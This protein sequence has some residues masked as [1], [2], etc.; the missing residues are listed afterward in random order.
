LEYEP[1]DLLATYRV[2]VRV[3][4]AGS[5]SAVAHEIGATQPAVSRQIAALEEFLGARLIQRTTRKLTLTEDGRDLLEHVHRVL[6]TV[7]ESIAAVGRRQSQPAGLV[8]LGCPVSFGRLA[9]APR[10]NRLLARYPELSLELVISDD[11]HDM[12][13]QG[14]DLAVR[15]GEVTDSSLVARRVGAVARGVLASATY[16]HKR[17]TPIHPSEL[18]THECVI[19][20]RDGS[21]R[22]WTLENG[23]ESTRVRVNGRFATDS[24]EV[25]REA[26]L[27]HVGIAILPYALAREAMADGRVVSLMKDWRPGRLPLHA[28]YPTRRH[29]APRTRAV[30]DFLLDEF[31][32]DPA[33]SSYGEG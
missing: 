33:L 30:I 23:E 26:V 15:A 8:R 4:E 21:P 19:Y 24:L 25:M 18:Q 16:L 32:L 5:F 29:L 1:V 17:G 6:E 31:R 9:L 13:A 28:V 20:T 12:I 14:L 27:T 2:F 22:E 7:D 10:V 3:A 11:R